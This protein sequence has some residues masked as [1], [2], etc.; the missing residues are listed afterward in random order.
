MED[1]CT[2]F[3]M[4][5]LHQLEAREA[6]AKM[7]E[8]N[9]ILTAKTLAVV[10]T[11]FSVIPNIS[12][13]ADSLSRAAMRVVPNSTDK[14]FSGIAY[15]SICL[16][17]MSSI[18]Q[19]QSTRFLPRL[20]RRRM[21]PHPPMKLPFQPPLLFHRQFPLVHARLPAP[22]QPLLNLRHPLQFS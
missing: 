5:I 16:L 2:Q 13:A 4:K 11:G 3:Q 12:F 19:P 9:T 20:R 10:N 7:L 18:S 6:S 15:G 17:L 1:V 8:E 21:Y 22:L 14:L